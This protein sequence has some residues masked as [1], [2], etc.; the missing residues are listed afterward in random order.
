MNIILIR[1]F[2][3]LLN[4]SNQILGWGDAPRADDWQPDL[5]FVYNKLAATDLFFDAIYTSVLE[6]SY[7][8]GRYFA[9]AFAVEDLH[10][11]AQ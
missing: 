4:A 3:T 9:Q 8:T 10:K 5:Q 11:Q 7:Q 1:H 2:K 6:R